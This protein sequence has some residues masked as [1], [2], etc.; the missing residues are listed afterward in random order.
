MSLSQLITEKSARLKRKLQEGKVLF[1][2][3]LTLTDPTCA[4]IMAQVG[5]D[6]VF[7]DM[8]HTVID[9]SL[10]HGMLMGFHGTETVPVVRVPSH[11]ADLIK[12]VLD[13][14]VGGVV[15]PMVSNAEEARAAVAACKYPPR[16][17]RGVGPRR[18]GNYGRDT[19]EYC[20]MANDALITVILVEHYEGVRNIDDILQVEGI[21]AIMIGDGDL[22]SSMGFLGREEEP[23][24][25]EAV[26][27]IMTACK[28]A[29]M[30]IMFDAPRNAEEAN[31]L[32]RQGGQFLFTGA[33]I[34]FLAR[35]AN[36]A[37]HK[38]KQV[39]PEQYWKE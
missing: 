12:R 6:Y 32:L 25:Q 9:L 2:A 30:P 24:V 3:G 14:G 29:G 21:D 17:I 10:L 20:Q 34:R 8:E 4:E 5:L 33:D 38:A 16:G 37:L 11:D 13:L 18:A 28:A 31:R 19:A 26:N 15:V 22:A 39:V 7:I 1:G 27:L 23:D 35:A 36:D